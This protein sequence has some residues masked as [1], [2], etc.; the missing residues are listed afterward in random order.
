MI[1]ARA[2]AEQVIIDAIK[3]KIKHIFFELIP[4]VRDSTKPICKMLREYPKRFNKKIP[5]RIIGPATISKRHSTKLKLPKRKERI[6]RPFS[7]S[8]INRKK[9]SAVHNDDKAMP[10][11]M[12]FE[13]FLLCESKPII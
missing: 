5:Q 4:K 10:V 11:N 12:I 2:T 7:L 13:K 1:P 8:S 6:E 3:I 9:V